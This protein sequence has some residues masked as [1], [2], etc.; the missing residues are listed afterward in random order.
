M[1]DASKLLYSRDALLE[2]I[3]SGPIRDAISLY[4]PNNYIER[5]E[6]LIPTIDDML[7]GLVEAGDLTFVYYVIGQDYREF[8]AFLTYEKADDVASRI[9][10]KVERRC[11]DKDSYYSILREKITS[12]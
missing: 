5:I 7:D 8:G 12:D 9:S 4:F 6:D 1:N 3:N 11:V 2:V 10:G